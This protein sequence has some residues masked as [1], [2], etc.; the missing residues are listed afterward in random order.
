MTRTIWTVGSV[1][2]DSDLTVIASTDV[3]AIELAADYCDTEDASGFAAVV[4]AAGNHWTISSFRWVGFESPS[5]G[6]NQIR[7]ML[8][9]GI[10]AGKIRTRVM[11]YTDGTPILWEV[12]AS[13]ET[14]CRLPA[15]VLCGG[16]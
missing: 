10:D 12:G 11:G 9:A 5:D 2:S 3:E 16:G 14:W 1:D 13:D 15:S 6:E 7:D 4:S 8:A